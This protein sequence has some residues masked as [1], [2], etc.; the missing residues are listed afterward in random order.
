M[1]NKVPEGNKGY[2]I[3]NDCS[4]DALALLEAKATE[5][6]DFFEKYSW[7]SGVKECV[8][9]IYNRGNDFFYNW[10]LLTKMQMKRIHLKEY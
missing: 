1:Y 8:Q 9:T 2:F 4:P 3:A 10:R 7:P 5:D 6:S